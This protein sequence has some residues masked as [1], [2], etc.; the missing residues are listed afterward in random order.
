MAAAPAEPQAG[1]MT[2]TTL[3]LLAVAGALTLALTG[4][5]ATAPV[6]TDDLIPDVVDQGD[7]GGDAGGSNDGQATVIGAD[8]VS[9]FAAIAAETYAEGRDPIP[10]VE[11]TSAS[12]VTFTF[13]GTLDEAARIGNCQ[14][15]YG[16][17]DAE[18]IAIT[19]VDDSGSFH[20]TALVEG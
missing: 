17:L 13:P 12:A 9:S 18:G 19:I 8:L 4:C 2:T 1:G 15:A 7:T 20:C 11:F 10:T 16:V 5:S 14:I 3:R 6:S